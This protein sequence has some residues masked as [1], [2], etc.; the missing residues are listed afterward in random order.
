L[1]FVG[2]GNSTAEMLHQIQEHER[3]T[4]SRID[5][6]VLTHYPVSAIREPGRETRGHES[7]FRDVT[8][9]VL[10]RLAGDLNHIFEVF[11]QAEGE[12]KIIANVASWHVENNVCVVTDKD[13]VTTSIP[14]DGL[15]TLTGYRQEPSDLRTKGI[16]VIEDYH[17]VGAFDYDGEVQCNPGALGRERVYP[18]YFG[19]GPIVRNRFNP[20]AV[21]IPGIQYQLSDM[22]PTIAM[23]AAEYVL[24]TRDP[25]SAA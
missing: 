20:N 18:G 1:V 21:V 14:Y 13:G 3:Q 10:T 16:T 6:R 9:P 7:F 25:A 23:R 4:G 12:G 24:R 22:L 17:G 5:Y 11:E 19:I 15:Y 8:Q 2:F